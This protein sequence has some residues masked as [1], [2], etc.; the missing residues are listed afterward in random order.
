MDPLYP[1][2][3]DENREKAQWISRVTIL[4]LHPKGIAM[5]F[6]PECTQSKSIALSSGGQQ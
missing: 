1:P 5:I 4:I 6:R 3:L 2:G